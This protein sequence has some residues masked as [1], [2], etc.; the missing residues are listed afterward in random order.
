MGDIPRSTSRI[1]QRA[2]NWKFLPLLIPFRVQ[3]SGILFADVRLI[4][5]DPNVIEIEKLYGDFSKKSPH[6]P[7]CDPHNHLITP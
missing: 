3:G 7:Y 4:P 5:F 1:A 2:G 6:N